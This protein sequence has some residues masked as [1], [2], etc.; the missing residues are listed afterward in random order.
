MWTG[1]SEEKGSWKTSWTSAL[2]L[3]ELSP[4]GQLDGLAVQADRPRREPL[5][6]RQELGHG[7]LPRTTFAYERDHGAAVKVETDIVNSGEH[8]SPPEPEVLVE[9]YSLHRQ[10]TA[11]GGGRLNAINNCARHRSGNSRGG[12]GAFMASGRDVTTTSP[13]LP[14]TGT[15]VVGSTNGHAVT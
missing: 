6:A 15:G 3:T 14:G 5:L 11:L 8:L 13:L 12:H 2:Y 7:G 10:R 9:R 1:F 4:V